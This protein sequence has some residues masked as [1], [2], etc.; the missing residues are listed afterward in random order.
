MLAVVSF[1]IIVLVGARLPNTAP[2]ERSALLLAVLGDAPQSGTVKQ[3]VGR[4]KS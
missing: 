3:A 1:F 2:L 4:L